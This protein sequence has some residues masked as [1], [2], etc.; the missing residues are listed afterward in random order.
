M[1]WLEFEV[2]GTPIT[3]GSKSGQII[4]QRVM[5]GRAVYN[6]RVILVDQTNM[7]TKTLKSGRLDRW[8]DSV[9]EA[10]MK[11]MGRAQPWLGPIELDL[12]FVLTRPKGNWL[13]SGALSKSAPR[14]HITKPDRGKLARAVED[15]LSGVVYKDDSQVCC[16]E[17]RKRY[18]AVRGAYPGVIVKVRRIT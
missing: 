17:P 8:R 18:V 9:T 1:V 13:K 14:Y 16:G 3:Q 15:A 5:G 11:A 7:A 10:A 4:G 2:M 6:P 12:E